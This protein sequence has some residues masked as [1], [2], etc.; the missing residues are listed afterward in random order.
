MNNDE[1]LYQFGLDRRKWR[2]D[3]RE[4]KR[5]RTAYLDTSR[6]LRLELAKKDS[7]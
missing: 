6:H 5:Q 7:Q 3:L 4:V 1:L 2:H